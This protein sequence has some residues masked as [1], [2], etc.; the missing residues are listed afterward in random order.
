MQTKAR[1]RQLCT[2]LR[3]FSLEG[4]S[5]CEFLNQIKNI[6]DELAGVGHLMQLEEHADAILEGLP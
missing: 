3:T 5:I 2:E 1:A 4:K 6:A